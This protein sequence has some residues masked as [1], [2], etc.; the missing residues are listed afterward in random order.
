MRHRDRDP[1]DVHGA[2]LVEADQLV[3][4]DALPVEPRYELD[5]AEERAAE[6]LVQPDRVGGVVAVPVC[7]R[8]RVGAFGLA[9]TVGARR[10]REERVDIDAAAS[11][12]V[13]PK[14]GVAEPGERCQTDPFR[15]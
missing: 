14:R 1:S 7:E 9:F 10:P 5:H 4:G 6:P 2:A 12:G 11:V 8:D 13:E 15:R 3:V